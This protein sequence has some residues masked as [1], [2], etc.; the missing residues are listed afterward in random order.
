MKKLIVLL[1]A[2]LP[3]A[4]NAQYV[5]DAIRY[6]RDI[7][8]GTARYTAL[9]GAMSSLG[10]NLSAMVQNPAGAATYRRSEISFTPAMNLHETSSAYQG[11]IQTDNYKN[12]FMLNNMGFVAAFNSS[13]TG[14]WKRMAFGFTYNRRNL[15]HRN[16]V[17]KGTNENNSLTSQWVHNANNDLWS[18]YYE[19]LG[20][21]SYLMWY[22]TDLQEYVTDIQLSGYGQQVRKV[23]ET[24][25]GMGQYDFTFAGDYAD[26]LSLGGTLGISTLQ[27]EE[28]S[29]HK[30]SDDEDAIYNFDSFKF[31]EDL[32]ITGIGVNLKMGI[33]FKPAYWVRIGVAYHSPTFFTIDEIFE[34]NVRHDLDEPLWEGGDDSYVSYPVDN[35][36]HPNDVYYDEP[37]YTDLP[38]TY[39]YRTPSKFVLGTSFVLKKAGL[40]SIDYEYCDYTSMKFNDIYDEES[41]A[42]DNLEISRQY[43]AVHNLR[44]GVEIITDPVVLR[45]GIAWYGSPYSQFS[46][47]PADN[48]LIY[49]AGIGFTG[50]YAY[51][52]LAWNYAPGS[53]DDVLYSYDNVVEAADIDFTNTQILAT[54]GVRF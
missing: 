4:A 36:G 1:I 20:W 17:I 45:G 30:E 13:Y 41:F 50:K 8:Y 40:L 44:A 54:L 9:G 26:K 42:D 18:N 24:R 32:N 28:T 6:S 38:F 43:K 39:S 29:S 3:I 46:P 15:F 10:G 7:Q 19:G 2:C 35:D 53:Y 33:I 12:N 14:E 11:T 5:E 34:S 27:V 51:F 52:D 22:N 48:R 31:D 47:M 23:T 25:G 49:S 16:V 37:I 21:T